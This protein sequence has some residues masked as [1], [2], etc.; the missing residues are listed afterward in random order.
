[1]HCSLKIPVCSNVMLILAPSRSLWASPTPYPPTPPIILLAKHEQRRENSSKWDPGRPEPSVSG[2]SFSCFDVTRSQRRHYVRNTLAHRALLVGIV[3]RYSAIKT[4][5]R[6]GI[7]SHT[8]LLTLPPKPFPIQH[9]HSFGV[10]I[11]ANK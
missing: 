4:Q 7:P 10:K 8:S 2:E 1:M 6:K 9:E 11:D 5:K 3:Q